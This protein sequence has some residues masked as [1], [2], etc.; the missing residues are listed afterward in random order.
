MP[1]ASDRTKAFVKDWTRLTHSGR[2]DM[3]RLRQVML[4]LIANDAPRGP[5]WLD[6]ALV[7]E[8]ADHRECHIG[9]DFLLVYQLQGSGAN[10]QIILVRVDTHDD[11]FE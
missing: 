10:E 9:D 6:H 7:G 2:F 4:A 1:R 5:E 11:L 8:W 3:K